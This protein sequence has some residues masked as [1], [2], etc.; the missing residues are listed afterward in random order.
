MFRGDSTGRGA[1]LVWCQI[2]TKMDLFGL[3]D[4]H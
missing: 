3:K 2:D 1:V 4:F